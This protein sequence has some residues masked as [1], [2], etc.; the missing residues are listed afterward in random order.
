MHKIKGE[1]WNTHI[2]K[3]VAD[4]CWRKMRLTAIV[5]TPI[6]QALFLAL[7]TSQVIYCSP[8]F[9]EVGT[10][11]VS[12]MHKRKLKQK[13]TVFLARCHRSTRS[14]NKVGTWKVWHRTFL[15]TAASHGIISALL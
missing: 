8:G 14:K 10:N 7:D 1:D 12:M 6:S 13:D 9:Q 5:T 2:Q 4:F 11:I 15:L 3:K